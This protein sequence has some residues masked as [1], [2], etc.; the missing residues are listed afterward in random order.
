MGIVFPIELTLTR[1]E[2]M[3]IYFGNDEENNLLVKKRLESFKIDYEEHSSKDIDY[4]TLLNWFTNSSDMFEFLQPRLMRYKLDNRLIFSQFV[5]KILNDIDNSLKLPLAVT[6]T[7]IIPGLTPG[8]V[9]I[10]LPPEYR[11]TERIQLYHQL[12][13]LDTERRFWRN[14]KIFREQSGL[15]WFEFNQ[16]MFS[17]TS[18][19]LGEV[20]RAKDNFF[21]YKR[22]LKIPPQEQIEKAAKVLMIEPE[23]FFTKTVS[24]LRNF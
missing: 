17:D 7:N 14:L 15:R 19:D 2:M 5:L 12:N 16:L 1:C 10:F 9:T 4:Q 11:K 13:Q 6:D 22:N 23:D 8:E 21:A 24:D 18:D 20:K 3:K